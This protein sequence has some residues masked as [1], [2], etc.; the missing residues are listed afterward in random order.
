MTPA[1]L[2]HLAECREL[3]ALCEDCRR[4]M[5]ADVPEPPAPAGLRD[6]ERRM[7]LAEAR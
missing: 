4:I 1:N 2:Q 5:W 7:F 3:A 6:E